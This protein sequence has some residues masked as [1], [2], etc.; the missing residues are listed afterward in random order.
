[1]RPIACLSA[2]LVLIGGPLE[3]QQPSRPAPTAAQQIAAAVLPLPD[4]MRAGARVYGYTAD[5]HFA[6]LRAG[7]G[8]MTCLISKPGAERFQVAC[9]HNSMEE[10][11]ARGRELRAQGVTAIDSVRNADVMA[12]RV[13]LPPVASLYSLNGPAGSWDPATNALTGV[14]PLYVVYLPFATEASTGISATPARGRPWLM[15]PGEP[16]AHVMIVPERPAAAP[17]P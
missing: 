7:T 17:R 11:M 13:H 5:G 8:S 12:G 10:F 1:M 3:A 15:H 4:S 9:Y 14:S 16:G 6:E 2:A